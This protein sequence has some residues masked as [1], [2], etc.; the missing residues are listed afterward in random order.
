M[1]FK[2]KLI[3]N[4]N[5]NKLF[6]K[7]LSSSS[8]TTNNPK[9]LYDKIFESHIV[10]ES[11]NGDVLLYIDRHLIHEVTSAQAFEGLRLKGRNVRRTECNL[12]TPDHNVTTSKERVTGNKK[13]DDELGNIQLDELDRN[14]VEF[15]LPYFPLRDK[16]QGIVHVI[17][18]EQGFTQP[19]L[20]IVC[21][22][23]HTSTHGAF[24]ALAHGIG[25]S[26][27]EHVLATQ[28]LQQRKS[29]NMRITVDGEVNEL[30][31]S[32]DIILA[33]IAE[34]GTAGGTGHVIEYAGKAI[35]DLSMEGRMTVCNMSI[36]AGAK[37]GLIAPD[38][39]TFDYLKG[40]P[41][42]PGGE[43]WD[44]AV[45]YWKTL[46]SDNGASYDKEVVLKA[47]DI[48]PQVTWGNNILFFFIYIFIL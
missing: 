16:R 28:T 44:K 7:S 47:A 5:T 26:E 35:S 25:T 15:K 30:I 45:D 9:T 1:L 4:N 13:G 40:R 46:P 23:S 34:I 39:I 14:A 3:N 42:A 11:D 38:N 6:F 20:T 29:K 19:G 2:N 8:N 31:T 17:G 48:A 37:A 32:K 22:D 12:V 41:M 36:E 27:V 43:L 10:D 33:I 21:G 18:P 24:G